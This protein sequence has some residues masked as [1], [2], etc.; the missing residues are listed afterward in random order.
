[1]A[2]LPTSRDALLLTVSDLL[3]EGEPEEALQSV[4]EAIGKYFLCSRVGFRHLDADNETYDCRVCWTDKTVPPLLG[5]HPARDFGPKLVAKLSRGETLVVEDLLADPLSDEPEPRETAQRLDTRAILVVPFLW[6][7]RLRS[8]IYLNNRTTRSWTS[9][10]ISLVQEVA[11]RTRR[12]IE[13]AEITRER[14][15]SMERLQFFDDLTREAARLA[16]ANEI[17]RATTRMVGE[18]LGV[19]V[20]A[21][22][23]MDNDEDGFTIRGDWNAPGSPT[24]VGHYRLAAFGRRAVE[25][26][27]AGRP[28]VINNNLEELAPGEAKTFQDLGISATICMPLVKDG[29]LVALMAIHH[30]ASHQWTE[31]ELTLVREV[32]ERSWA[33]VERV[34]AEAELRKSEA[35]LE[36]ATSAAEI[37]IWDW[38]IATNK[39]QYSPRAKEIS[40]FVPESEVDYDMVRAIVHPDDYPITSEQARRALDPAAR[41]RRAYE[42]RLVKPDG[43]VRW[44]VAHGTAVFVGDGNAARPTRYIGTL[45]DITETRRLQDAERDALARL[46]LALDAGRMAVWE[47]DF[48]KDALIGSPELNCILGFPKDAT[49]TG[50]QIRARYYPGERERLRALTQLALAEGKKF[51]EAE[52]RY[53]WPGGEVHWLLL[54]CEVKFTD[55]GAMVRAVGVVTD[56][57]ARRKVEEQ[58][59]LL[60]AELNHRVKNTLA[61]VVSIERQSFNKSATVEEGR[62]SFQRRVHALAQTHT[63]LSEENW[64][65][66]SLSTLLSDELRPYWQ[67]SSENVFI[68][69]PAI[70]LKSKAALTLGLAIHEL[71]T[72]AAKHGALST[73]AGRVHVDWRIDGSDL[74]FTWKE[75][76]G[77]QVLPPTRQGFGVFLLE[78]GIS[79]DLQGSVRLGFEPEGF[80][81]AMTLPIESVGAGEIITA[82]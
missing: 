28:L 53:I 51:I 69:G 21:Y 23:D 27:R 55:D 3:Q 8:M 2:H 60:V 68:S 5:R 48:N 24:I 42:Y 16:D 1:M 79:A 14:R 52:F 78:R 82:A 7:G 25:N 76:V 20:C 4:C 12:I 61:T 19:S 15:Q 81:C 36:I 11:A 54:R 45:Q 74:Q 80:Q 58:R 6:T 29:R 34:G 41:E 73:S 10:E 66:V 40:G 67:D 70:M 26:L 50:D 9:A 56:V 63:R 64:A 43:T 31:K 77:R 71:T 18:H 65:G 47:A 75:S 17:L 72:N 49:P 32:T 59:E 46:R 62:K 30:K 35:R 57:T 44:V 38:D 13:L 22:A 39:M 33:H 37:G